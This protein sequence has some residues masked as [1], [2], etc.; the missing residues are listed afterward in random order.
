MGNPGREP[1][2]NVSG[3]WAARPTPTEGAFRSGPPPLGM[4]V[5]AG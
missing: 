3:I 4:M 5:E 1:F 2:G